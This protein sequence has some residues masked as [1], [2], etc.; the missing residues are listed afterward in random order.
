M[1]FGKRASGNLNRFMV[2]VPSRSQT[3]VEIHPVETPTPTTSITPLLLILVVTYGLDVLVYRALHA[4]APAFDWVYHFSLS[5]AILALFMRR[6]LSNPHHPGADLFAILFS[7]VF[8]NLLGVFVA[9]TW[10]PGMPLE[11]YS[12]KLK[13]LFV[14]TYLIA[15]RVLPSARIQL[16]GSDGGDAVPAPEPELQ[17]IGSSELMGITMKSMTIYMSIA[18]LSWYIIAMIVPSVSVPIPAA[19]GFLFTLWYILYR[20][21]GRKLA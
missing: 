7:L 10:A 18:L 15:L 8:G 6:F 3:A 9:T 21:H 14:I 12:D 11:Q 4:Y 17:T 5:T 19:I 1:A 16:N 13:I 2:L 20:T